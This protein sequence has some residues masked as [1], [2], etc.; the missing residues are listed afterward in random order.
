MA[1]LGAVAFWLNNQEEKAGSIETKAEERLFAIDNIDDVKT[2]T[3]QK[4]MARGQ[5]FEK[6]NGKWILNDTFEVN[7]YAFNYLLQTL[8]NMEIQNIPPENSV[9][10]IMD[11]M[12]RI[13]IKVK[14]YDENNQLMRSII[15]GTQA[16]DDKG[17]S[18]LVEGASQPYNIFM[19]GFDG[20]IRGRFDH[21]IEEWRSKKVL[22][23]KAEDIAKVS[24]DY[25]KKASSGFVLNNTE[26]PPTVKPFSQFVDALPQNKID[27]NKIRAYLREFERLHGEGFDNQNPK[28]DSIINTVP[29]ATLH[30]ERKNGAKKSV[31]FFP[32]YDMID[33]NIH[34]QDAKDAEV[35]NRFFIHTSEDDFM[36]VQNVVFGKIFVGYEHFKK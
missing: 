9:P 1:A 24:M 29:F 19:R 3:L 25:H 34:I 6:V 12:K 10:T 2:I 33:P 14:A 35:I 11:E 32:F 15:V 31:S 18:M 16:Y 30:M 4:G 21:T 26:Q 27:Q 8:N 13:G 5:K 20:E 28:K 17:T 7:P 23:V 36:L 22:E